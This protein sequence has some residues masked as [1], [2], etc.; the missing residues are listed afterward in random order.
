MC[1]NK[2]VLPLPKKP[3]NMVTGIKAMA[4]QSKNIAFPILGNLLS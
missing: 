3:V 1:F 2:V 4:I